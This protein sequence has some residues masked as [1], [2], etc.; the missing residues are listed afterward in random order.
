MEQRFKRSL[1]ALE[2]V[3]DFVDRFAEV[4]RIDETAAF[5][6]RLA[7]EELFT[8]FVR[9]NTGGGAD[10][11]VRL[12]VTDNALVLALTDFD[13]DPVD[14]G[15]GAAPDIDLPLE[16]RPIGG[17]GI[18]L[19]RSMVDSLTYEYTGRTLHVTAVKNLEDMHV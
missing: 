10:I 12:D 19:V 9:H 13:V 18:H 4:H 14:F 1:D 16:K 6:A 11:A 7:A 8:N 2:A 3:F 17:L 5:T 15:R